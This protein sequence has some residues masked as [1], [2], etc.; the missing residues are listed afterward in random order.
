LDKPVGAFENEAIAE[1]KLREAQR[2]FTAMGATGHSE[3]I[4]QQLS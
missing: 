4:A 2:L 3:R 1:T